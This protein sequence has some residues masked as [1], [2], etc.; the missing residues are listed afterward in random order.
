MKIR[1][2][3]YFSS[4]YGYCVGAQGGADCEIR[5]DLMHMRIRK[6]CLSPVVQGVAVCSEE[7]GVVVNVFFACVDVPHATSD[8]FI[9][10]ISTAGL[11]RL[12]KLSIGDMVD[13][14]LLV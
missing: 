14:G 11:S 9:G 10:S 8:K 12:S 7:K 13:G 2:D 3:T 4:V 6:K 5:S 1:N